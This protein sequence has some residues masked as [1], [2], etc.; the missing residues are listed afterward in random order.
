M[1][2]DLGL[3]NIILSNVVTHHLVGRDPLINGYGS[4]L[5]MPNLIGLK[6]LAHSGLLSVYWYIVKMKMN[7]GKTQ[8]MLRR[9]VPYNAS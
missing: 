6:V 8:Q 5:S 7:T 4:S 9:I 3:E 2:G 1:N